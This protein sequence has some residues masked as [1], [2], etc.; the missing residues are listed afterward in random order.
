MIR[1][2]LSRRLRRAAGQSGFTMLETAFAV[3]VLAIIALGLLPLGFVATTTTE[4]QGHLMARTTEYAQDKM[5]QLLSLAYGDV[6]SDTRVFPAA[7]TGGS[8]LAIGGS[9]DPAAPVALYVDYLD[10]N[11]SLLSSSGTTAPANW[12]YQRV[13]KVESPGTNLKKITVTAI[14][15]SASG[16]TGRVPRASV[17]SVKTYPF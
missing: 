17:A 9:S 14:T 15:K 3:S 11:G 2:T 5:E 8:G 1:T 6:T 13:W 7:I 16:S 10:I 4:N 12:Y